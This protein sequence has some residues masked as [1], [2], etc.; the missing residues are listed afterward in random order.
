[1]YSSYFSDVH[2]LDILLLA[3]LT[4]TTCSLYMYYQEIWLSYCTPVWASI[5]STLAITH[6]HFSIILTRGCVH[7]S[8]CL[9]Q[10]IFYL[11][12]LQK[13]LYVKDFFLRDAELLDV[14]VAQNGEYFLVMDV[15]WW[16]PIALRFWHSLYT[17]AKLTHLVC[18]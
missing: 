1:M 2:H 13:E 9:L 18:E 10:H 3:S 7:F 17:N 16:T 11:L 8:Y 5:N 12:P 15:P 14:R 4:V 6:S